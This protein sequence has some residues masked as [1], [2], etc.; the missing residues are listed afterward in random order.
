MIRHIV[1]F[2]LRPDIDPY[3]RQHVMQD[4]RDT[5]SLLPTRIPQ[6]RSISVH[7]NTNPDEKWDL[8]LDS[9]FDSLEDV[10]T[11]AAHPDH[12]EVASILDL[13]KED[14]ACVDIELP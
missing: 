8:M 6:I 9:L 12:I 4:F 10:R 2:R 3:L 13:W 11:Y 1:L 7:F 14:R 5:V